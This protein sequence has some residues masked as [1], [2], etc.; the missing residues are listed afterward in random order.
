VRGGFDSA[1]PEFAGRFPEAFQAAHRL[2]HKISGD[3]VVT[4]DIEKGRILYKSEGFLLTLYASSTVPQAPGKEAKR[5][6]NQA[7]IDAQYE[8]KLL[9]PGTRLKSDAVI[10][11]YD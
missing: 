7:E 5:T 3:G 4:L 6:E 9:P 11:D 2:V 1:V 10:P 8:I